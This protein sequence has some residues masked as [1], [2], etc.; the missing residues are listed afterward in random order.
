MTSTID[1]PGTVDGLDTHPAPG[2]DADAPADGTDPVPADAAG[3]EGF[4]AAVERADGAG[5]ATSPMVPHS[6]HS[7]QRGCAGQR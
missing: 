7:G 2:A 3:V 5:P 1:T 4:D 6:P